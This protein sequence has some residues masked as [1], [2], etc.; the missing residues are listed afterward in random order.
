MT[1]RSQTEARDI[2]NAYRAANDA[3]DERPGL[4]ARNAI[5]AAAARAVEA[6]PAAVG[7]LPMR[8]WRFPL[9]AAATVLISTIAVIIA[10]RTE[11][12]MPAALIAESNAPESSQAPSADASTAGKLKAAPAAAVVPAPAASGEL[13]AVERKESI[14]F[15][16]QEPGTDERSASRREPGRVRSAPATARADQPAAAA[17]PVASAATDTGGQGPEPEPR[18][19]RNAQ[20][21]AAMPQ[22]AIAPA[23][24]AAPPASPAV[25]GA[26]MRDARP[27]VERAEAAAVTSEAVPAMPSRAKTTET[28]ERWLARIIELRQAARDDEADAELKKLRELHPDLTIPAAALR[29]AGTR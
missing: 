3:L 24:D 21:A 11:R 10:Q 13:A 1:N 6:K 5:L 4:A 16:R 9:A 20:I 8:R 19:R 7:S 29:R 2:A 25:G 23:A 14:A 28:P 17:A 18:A 26:L 22:P 12:E 15:A 27:A